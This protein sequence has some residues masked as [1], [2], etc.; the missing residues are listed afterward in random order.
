MLVGME[1][2]SEGGGATVIEDNGCLSQQLLSKEGGWEEEEVQQ[3]VKDCC[4]CQFLHWLFQSA[5]AEQGWKRGGR[6][7]GEEVQQ[8]RG[9]I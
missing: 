6:R 2:I 7:N 1:G 3:S 5:A 4:I 8:C 9:G